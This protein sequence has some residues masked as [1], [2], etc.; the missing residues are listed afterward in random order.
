MPP[1]PW[2]VLPCITLPSFPSKAPCIH[3]ASLE[4]N[5]LHVPC[6]LPWNVLSCIYH[7][8]L[9]VE[10]TT[11]LQLPGLPF[12]G[13]YYPALTMPYFPWKVLLYIY[14]QVVFVR[15][16]ILPCIYHASVSLEG[17]TLHLPCLFPWIL[18]CIT[19]AFISL[20]GS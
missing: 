13:R 20:E 16:N 17:T 1:F 3:H 10:C 7:A 11:T 19:N 5:T 18:L 2:N 8:S 4:P 6:L 9:F 12:S 14:L 15:W